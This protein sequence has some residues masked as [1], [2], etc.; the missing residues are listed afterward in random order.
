MRATWPGIWI[1]VA[2]L[3][4]CGDK[5]PQAYQGYAEGEFVRIAAPY[6]GSLTHLAVQ[7]GADIQGGAPL[8]ALERD[9][10]K[11]AREEAAQRLK[12][13]E[14]QLEN[15]KKGRRPAEI[16]AILAQREQARATLKLAQADYERD[17]K[18]AASGFVSPQRLDASRAALERGRQQMKEIEAQLAVARLAARSDDIRAAE[19]AADAARAAL[20][21]A[22]WALAQKSVTAP[23]GGQ[24]QDT[25]YVQGEWVPAGSPVVVLLPPQNLKVRFF[26]PQARLAA[27]KT[28]QPVSISCDGCAAPIAATVSYIAPQA[29]YTPPVIYSQENRDKLVFLVEA[30]PKPEDAAKLRPGQPVDVRL[31]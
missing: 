24:V 26:I 27:L 2:A 1:A 8:F 6:A 13:A 18:L 21:R 17:H 28:G 12:Q 20:A 25:L 11:A 22:D 31:N 9:N 30:R 7:R 29:E 3:A 5:A 15:L 23:L 19:A 4:G 10:E 16:D 14:A